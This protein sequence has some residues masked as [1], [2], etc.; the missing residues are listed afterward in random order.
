MLTLSLV[1]PLC[2]YCALLFTKA[3][4]NKLIPWLLTSI[5]LT[6]GS[7]F[8]LISF[9]DS[10]SW[11]APKVISLF[12]FMH[13]GDF[14]EA[15]SL[16]FTSSSSFIYFIIYILSLFIVLFC[17][18]YM[19]YKQNMPRLLSDILLLVFTMLLLISAD[20]LL[21]LLFAYE[22]QSICIYLAIN[23]TKKRYKS[24]QA[25]FTSLMMNL[26]ADAL[27]AGTAVI[28]FMHGS[29]ELQHLG[30]ILLVL[31]AMAKGGQTGFSV[32]V[33]GTMEAPSPT[34]ALLNGLVIPLGSI[35]LLISFLPLA[36]SV[37]F[38]SAVIIIGAL[39]ALGGALVACLQH[40]V[41]KI[42]AYSTV[43]QIGLMFIAI[44]EGSF[45]PVLLLFALH[46][47]AK[48]LLFLGY[49]EVIR[50][51]SG[52]H[53]IRH[54]GGIGKTL[55]FSCLACFAGSIGIILTTASAISILTNYWLL[56][57]GIMTAFFT[58]IYLFRPWFHIFFGPLKGEEALL[59]RLS[60]ESTLS[61]T[62]ITG[63]LLS[64][65][66][67][68]IYFFQTE[69]SETYHQLLLAAL[70]GFAA[71]AY[72]FKKD[73]SFRDYVEFSWPRLYQFLK[74]SFGGE[75]FYY[76]LLPAFIIMASK[77]ISTIPY[78]YSKWLQNIFYELSEKISSLNIHTNQNNITVNIFIIIISTIILL[79]FALII[80]GL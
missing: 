79:S 77:E 55:K 6:I 66:L 49:A 37:F 19:Q 5:F 20:N 63:L 45:Y 47:A 61:I 71:I 26:F 42:L 51:M 25:A 64:T 31:A 65:I 24:N 40:E 35:T 7:I 32:W 14:K 39:G 72:A 78:K 38:P 75:D 52:E 54:F 17:L 60:R 33:S 62:A 46:G 70:I 27:I 21:L 11:E 43:S 22:L 67:A 13:F 69:D 3:E 23:F 28:I 56:F 53:D 16:K 29:P 34:A 1:I 76:H 15:F 50:T 68:S 48:I 74:K 59:A 2:G 12:S 58:G 8:S 18:P 44:G 9:V 36:E 73:L 57:T 30:M 41:K 4:D 10:L 80:I